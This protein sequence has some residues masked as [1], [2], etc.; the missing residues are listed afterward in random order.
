MNIGL[1]AEMTARTFLVGENVMVR[2]TIENRTGVAGEVPDPTLDETTPEYVLRFPDGKQKTLTR[3]NSRRQTSFTD[4]ESPLARADMPLAPAGIW[5]EEIPIDPMLPSVP[6]G[7]YALRVAYTVDG[8]RSV[9]PE[10]RFEILPANVV[11]FSAEPQGPFENDARLSTAWAHAGPSDVSIVEAVRN[12]RSWGRDREGRLFSSLV[13]RGP[14]EHVS[15]VYVPGQYRQPGMEFSNWVVWQSDRGVFALRTAAGRRLGDPVLLHK[16][17]ELEVVEP[18]VM[19]AS[20]KL[21]VLAIESGPHPTLLRIDLAHADHAASQTIYRV[22]LPWIPSAVSA[23]HFE[24]SHQSSTMLFVLVKVGT[25]FRLYGMAADREAKPSLLAEA[26]DGI[27]LP[28]H[29]LSVSQVEDGKT[30]VGAA[31]LAA[32]GKTLRVLSLA[33]DA[34]GTLAANPTTSDIAL[35]DQGPASWGS[36]AVSKSGA[37][38]LWRGTSQLYFS[39]PGNPTYAFA[40]AFRWRPAPALFAD[41][42]NVFVA[43]ARDD[44]S[45]GISQITPSLLKH[46]P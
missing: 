39:R 25:A 21:S 37:S 43:G 4:P 17:G 38:I 2:L 8:Q 35:D 32:G 12:S 28:G 22:T 6:P 7:T 13:Y 15:R 3:A 31:F 27:L 29:P 14:V 23:A 26:Q 11:A 20:Q 33:V 19:D 36:V 34:S 10:I 18:P 44:G 41:G 42:S 1:K 46:L 9:T 40:G 16:G 30:L 24:R 5:T 45:F